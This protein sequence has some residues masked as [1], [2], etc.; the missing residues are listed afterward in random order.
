MIETEQDIFAAFEQELEINYAEVFQQE[1]VEL[2]RRDESNNL[3]TDLLRKADILLSD[4]KQLLEYTE[5]LRLIDS[6]RT[7]CTHDHQVHD[8]LQQSMHREELFADEHDHV[9]DKDTNHTADKKKKSTYVKGF[10]LGLLLGKSK[11]HEKQNFFQ[12]IGKV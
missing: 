4:A 9:H 6:M 1:A 8:A 7:M 10:W 5:Y 2:L 12:I 11:K 3:A